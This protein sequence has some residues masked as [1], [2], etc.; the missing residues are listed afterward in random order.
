MINV[1]WW[2]DSIL[3]NRME[4]PPLKVS[5]F[6]KDMQYFDHREHI[7]MESKEY[8]TTAFHIAW[9]DALSIPNL[10]SRHMISYYLMVFFWRKWGVTR[11]WKRRFIQWWTDIFMQIKRILYDN[12]SYCFARCY[13]CISANK[14]K[15]S[16]IVL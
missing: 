11:W 9:Q 15:F 12:A 3:R 10:L 1:S 14:K 13:M 6:W 7:F 8:S 2:Y 4:P 5:T 16:L